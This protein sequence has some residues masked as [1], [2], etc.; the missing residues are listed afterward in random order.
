MHTYPSPLLTC[1]RCTP[2]HPK[3]VIPSVARDLLFAFVIPS[4]A[5]D[6]LFPFVIPSVARDLGPGAPLSGI[7]RLRDPYPPE[8]RLVPRLLPERIEVEQQPDQRHEPRLGL[9]PA[10]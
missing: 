9:D 10:L 6:L 2:C 5:R 4:V 7:H 8:K 3:A 1:E